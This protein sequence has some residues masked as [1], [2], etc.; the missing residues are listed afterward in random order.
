MFKT[1]SIFIKKVDL[2]L[3]IKESEWKENLLQNCISVFLYPC[4]CFFI[5][6]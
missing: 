3:K 6:S 2:E 4:M 1:S 5:S